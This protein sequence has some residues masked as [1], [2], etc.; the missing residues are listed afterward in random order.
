MAKKKQRFITVKLPVYP[1]KTI[2]GF[3][4]NMVTADFADG[5]QAVVSSG[6]GLGNTDMYVSIDGKRMIA[7]DARPLLT[8][9]I[10]AAVDA[11]R[12]A[13]PAREGGQGE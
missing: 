6:F 3:H 11:G 7:V 4:A 2:G 5:S 8:A 1:E 12:G 10:D 13:A 9:L